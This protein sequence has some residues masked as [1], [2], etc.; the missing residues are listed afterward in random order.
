LFALVSSARDT[1]SGRTKASLLTR[2]LAYWLRVLETLLPHRRPRI[3]LSAL[4]NQVIAERLA[5]T[6]LGDGD[7]PPG[8]LS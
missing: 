5:N 7:L 6:E 1:G 4:D 2:H 3:G 8:P